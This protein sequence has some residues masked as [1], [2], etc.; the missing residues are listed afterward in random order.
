MFSNHRIWKE[1]CFFL[2][3]LFHLPPCLPLLPRPS[4]L[5]PDL[6]LLF[7]SFP[8]ILYLLFFSVIL[9]WRN[10]TGW[11]CGAS[12]TR[13]EY[14]NQHLKIM[15]LFQDINATILRKLKKIFLELLQIERR[16]NK[17]HQGTQ[18][19]DRLARLVQTGQLVL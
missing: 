18:I 3:L 8:S 17:W 13:K 1:T 15:L 14:R 19:C 7:F 6:I 12:F 2:F 5:L 9:L 4:C 11:K 16:N 10:P